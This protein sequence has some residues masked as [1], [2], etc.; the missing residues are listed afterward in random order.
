MDV[1]SNNFSPTC[2]AVSAD[3]GFD[4]YSMAP[5]EFVCTACP[6]GYA[7]AHCERCA[8]G[9]FGNPLKLGDACRPCDCSGNANPFAPDWCDHRTGECLQC[10]G[11]TAGWKCDRCLEGFYGNPFSGK[12]RGT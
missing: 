11:N 2:E 7:G 9:Y 8:N 6:R 1:P 10:L 5:D 4:R 12:W 3:H